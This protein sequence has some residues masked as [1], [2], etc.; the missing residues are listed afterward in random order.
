MR[1]ES[2]MTP[3][4]SLHHDTTRDHRVAVPFT[5]APG[6][7]RRRSLAIG[8]ALLTGVGAPL[9]AWAVA[10]RGPHAAASSTTTTVPGG[11]A[12]N[13]ALAEAQ[14]NAA[15]LRLV[16]SPA[17]AGETACLEAAALPGPDVQR[18]LDD[19]AVSPT[20]AR[21]IAAAIVD[22]A[23]AAAVRAAL[24]EAAAEMLP[25]ASSECI[26]EVLDQVAAPQLAHTL[27][28]TITT[29]APSEP[30]ATAADDGDE[31]AAWRDVAELCGV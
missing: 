26:T 18:L 13:A 5:G 1:I 16:G 14:L 31:P 25:A 11:F 27:A 17:G 29:S 20:A 3:R 7:G 19:D 9:G 2:F 8:L 22:C 23:P 4:H 15:Y 21:S 6:R 28:A 10:S 12:G 24:A 30:P